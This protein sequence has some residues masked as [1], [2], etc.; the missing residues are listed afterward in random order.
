M[1]FLG[2]VWLCVWEMVLNIQN[3]VFLAGFGC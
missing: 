1:A 2:S 3:D